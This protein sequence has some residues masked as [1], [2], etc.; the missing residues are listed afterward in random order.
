MSLHVKRLIELNDEAGVRINKSFRSLVYEAGGYE[1]VPFV[2]RD[3]RNYMGQKR[4]ALGKDEETMFFVWLFET[5][6]RCMGGNP[7]VGIVTD[8]CKAMQMAIEIVFPTTRHRWCLW[9]IM[10]KIPEKLKSYLQYKS[11]K[12]EL[13]CV[14]YDSLSEA[15]FEPAWMSFMNKYGLEGNEWLSGLYHDRCKWVPCFLKKHFWVGMSTTQRS[16]SVNTFFDGYINASTNLQQFVKQ[17]ENALHQKHALTVLSQER[18]KE[19][20]NVYLL[21]RWSKNVRRK[22]TYI[23]CNYDAKQHGPKMCRFDDLC[24]EFYMIAE[25]AAETPEGTSL[26]AQAIVGVKDKVKVVGACS[27]NMYSNEEVHRTELVEE[28]NSEAADP[29]GGPLV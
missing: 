21:P 16:E 20:P 6:L 17:Y 3:I 15:E 4:R 9:H 29:V 23:K 28:R 11:M 27:H 5:W 13:K 1:N 14:V 18:V 8:Q 26:L 19:V 12:N 24:K 25:I 10:K 2:E 22:H 7:P